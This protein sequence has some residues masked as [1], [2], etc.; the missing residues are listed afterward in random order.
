MWFDVINGKSKR[1]PSFTLTLFADRVVTP[2][3]F[4]GTAKLPD[5]PG[6]V[7]APPSIVSTAG[8]AAALSVIESVMVRAGLKL[9]ATADPFR[10]I[11]HR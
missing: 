4:N 5:K 8:G 3:S 2:T 11:R 10:C 7:L 9:S 6:A 1:K